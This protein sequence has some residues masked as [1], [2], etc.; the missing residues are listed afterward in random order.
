MKLFNR[1]NNNVPT[2][3]ERLTVILEKTSEVE[4]ETNTVKKFQFRHNM[5][6][7]LAIELSGLL[8]LKERLIVRKIIEKCRYD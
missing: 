5:L 4:Q 8:P 7:A 3:T 2:L 6:L 1:K